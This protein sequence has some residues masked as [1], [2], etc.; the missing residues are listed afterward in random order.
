MPRTCRASLDSSHCRIFHKIRQQTL[1]DGL[2]L[3]AR[4][5]NCWQIIARLIGA[6]QP[7]LLIG[8]AVNPVHDEM[9]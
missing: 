5:Y 4:I 6:W 7:G 3:S 9:V 2:H 1:D 8:P